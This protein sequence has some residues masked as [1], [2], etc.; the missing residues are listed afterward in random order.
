MRDKLNPLGR[1]PNTMSGNHPALLITWLIPSLQWSTAVAA[2]SNRGVSQQQGKGDWSELREVRLQPNT[3]SF[4]KKFKKRA[5]GQCD[6]RL[7][8]WFTFHYNNDL[9]HTAKT[10]LGRLQHNM[11]LKGFPSEL[12]E[13]DRI[14]Q[15]E[16][17]KLHKSRGTEFFSFSLCS[18]FSNLKMILH[19]H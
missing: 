17:D 4:E 7:G 19:M 2:S 15:D 8:R 13:L 16:W 5:P 6:L 10:V 11:A 9:E 12:T 3:E 18:H 1:T 14:C